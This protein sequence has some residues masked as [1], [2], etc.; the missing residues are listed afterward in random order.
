MREP[1]IFGKRK[2]DTREVNIKYILLTEGTETEPQYFGAIEENK[3]L[4]EIPP[5]IKIIPLE[6]SHG[7]ECWSNPK[8]ILDRLL[9]NI[10]ETASEKITYNTLLNGIIDCLYYSEYLNKHQE[11][12]PELKDFL[13]QIYQDILKITP[14]D[15]VEDKEATVTKVTE[16]LAKEKPRICELIIK[17]ISDALNEQSIPYAPDIDKICL[18]VD[19]DP[20]SFTSSQFDYVKNTCATNNVQFYIS[21]PGFE[22]WLLMHSSNF[23]TMKDDLAAKF[24]TMTPPEFLDH[25][26]SLLKQEFDGYNKSKLKTQPFMQAID[27]AIA[28]EKMFTESVDALK[29][30]MGS[31]IGLLIQEMRR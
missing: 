21:N 2:G 20:M 31:N 28:N 30:D 22:L 8:K 29:N 3:G 1:K 10:E 23:A 12:I 26:E 4:L 17:N 25:T 14:D 5:I 27:T 7:E 18:V 6:R 9:L 16:F 19:R 11:K 13:N 24:S 15:F